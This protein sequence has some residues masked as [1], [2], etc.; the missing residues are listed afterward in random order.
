MWTIEIDS[1]FLKEK[2]KFIFKIKDSQNSKS[3]REILIV[4]AQVACPGEGD[5][6]I[7]PRPR[8]R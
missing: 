2:Q 6:P 4:L 8:V 7:F 1:E 5:T 3:R